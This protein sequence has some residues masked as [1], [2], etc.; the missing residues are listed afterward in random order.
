MNK[1]AGYG[2]DLHVSVGYECVGVSVPVCLCVCVCVLSVVLI[3]QR[4]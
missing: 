4:S 1:H 2:H 3:L